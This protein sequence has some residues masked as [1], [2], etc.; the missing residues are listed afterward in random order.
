MNTLNEIDERR[1]ATSAS[2]AEYDLACPARHLRQRG[3]PDT[4]SKE[5]ESG[6]EI[7]DALAL[8]DPAGLT[9]E[10]HE[11][12]D[13]CSRIERK[14]LQEFFGL[15]WQKAK[16][17]RENPK[18]PA[19]SRLW[20]RFQKDGGPVLEHSARLDVL[21]RLEA[22][23]L[24]VEYK[25][26]FGDI[27]ESPS[28]LQLRDQ[29]CIARRHYL[30]PGDIGVVVVQPE[31]EQDPEITVYTPDDSETATQQM[32]ARVE[33]SNNPKAPATAGS[34]QCS[35]CKAKTRC[36]EYSKWNAQMVPPAMLAVLD[37]PM[38]NWSPE[39]RAH[40][41]S[42][43]SAAYT[44]LE[45]I[46]G[47]LKE[48]LRNNPG[49]VPGWE[50]SPGRKVERINNPQVVFERFSAHG[51]SLPQFM[52]TITVGK[53]K[54]KEQLSDVTGAKGKALQQKLDELLNGVVDCTETDGSL[55]EAK[56]K[57]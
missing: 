7:H 24:I 39:Q 33:A 41:A 51:G 37:V 10:Q 19:A 52:A 16:P 5:S 22:R 23:A 26:L 21:W 27:P 14:K 28:N 47:F 40:A 56:A 35:F 3:M 25:T 2:N 20:V 36:A 46:K 45:T 43:L 57:Q 17:T 12:F 44:F 34:R 13:A 50:I 15:D 54:L 1:G 55:R 9:L 6:R 11:V 49:S 42:Q 29:Q 48:S 18:N 38:E 30:I 32:F 4:T 53:T 31:I 8:Q